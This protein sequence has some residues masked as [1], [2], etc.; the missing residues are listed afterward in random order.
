MK[1]IWKN[2]NDDIIVSSYGKIK[3]KN[4]ILK[5]YLHTKGY[6]ELTINNK[7]Y[8]IH[9]LVA[10]VFIENKDSLPQVNHKNGNKKDNRVDNLEWCTAKENNYHAIKNGLRNR[11]KGKSIKQ[12]SLNGNFIKEFKN[13]NEVLKELKINYNSHIYKCINGIRQSAYG[14]IWK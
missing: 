7:K 8:L 2:Y 10:S 1:E 14:Y 3:Y 4:R 13:I 11:Y 9:R 6:L 12:Y 5:P